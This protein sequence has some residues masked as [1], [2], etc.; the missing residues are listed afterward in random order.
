MLAVARTVLQLCPSLPAAVLL[1]A[2]HTQHQPVARPMWVLLS[3][4]VCKQR[5]AG[6]QTAL[7]QLLVSNHNYHITIH[8]LCT[9][10]CGAWYIDSNSHVRWR[11]MLPDKA[12]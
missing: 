3:S 12:E 5:L 7:C 11:A 2:L 8:G 4:G 1:P 10:K 9:P 6:P